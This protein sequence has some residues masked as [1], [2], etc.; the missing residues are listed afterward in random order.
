MLLSILMKNKYIETL[1]S[2]D[3]TISMVI[4][5]TF[6]S[7]AID[8]TIR[9][10]ALATTATIP[11]QQTI[12]NITTTSDQN[13][14]SDIASLGDPFYKE[15]TKSTGMRVI[16]VIDRPKVEVSFSGNGTIR[17]DINVSDIGTIWTIPT[18]GNMIY[19][20]G[21]GIL[22]TQDGE[23]ATYTQQGVGQI[24]PQGKVIFHGSMFFKTLSSSSLT[25]SK[26][27]FLNNMLGI[28]DYESDIAGN[29]IRQVW[30][31]K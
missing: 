26:L 29:A 17:D 8:N 3:M 13:T 1:V 11:I 4:S 12:G 5:W 14:T 20:Q 30:E 19:S 9:Q 24:T 6:L 10:E 22:T 25:S 23:I 28:Y 2:V 21:Q 18:S 7:S 15:R 27:A 16:D 31:W